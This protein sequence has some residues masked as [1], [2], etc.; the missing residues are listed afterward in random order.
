MG[1]NI[2]DA[3]GHVIE[4]ETLLDYLDEPYRSGKT[5]GGIIGPVRSVLG[6]VFPSLDF[7]HLVTFKRSERAFGGGKR[8]GP[9]QWIEFLDVA[10]FEYAV[11]YPTIGLAMG[12]ISYPDWACAVARAYNN[13]IHDR[14][15]KRSPRL[16]GMALLPMQDVGEAVLELRRA[17]KELGM[18]GAM[19]PSRGLPFDLGH[20][21]YWPVY[22]EAE[23]LGCALAVHGGCHHGMG[24][25]TL[26]TFVPIHGMGHPLSLLI[27]FSGMVYHG[28]FDE[29]PRLRVGFLEG[30]AAWVT[31]WMDRMDRSHHYFG[32]LDVQGRYKG[33]SMEQKPSDY[34]K[35]DNVFVGCEGGEEGLEYQV[36]RVGNHHFLFASDFPHEIGPEDIMHEIDEVREYPGLADE[37]KAAILGGNA[38]RFYQVPAGL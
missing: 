8:V 21:T 13:W 15:M 24:L 6:N 14:Y 25:D 29:F 12:N 34:L 16:K 18:P 22:A 32:E 28:A 3:D 35:R 26:E 31:F 11:L 30:G 37:D 19:L 10:K 5:K 36:R 20:P 1:M 27:A 9:E 33:P 38:R 4:D 23:K 7:H 2:I 17:V